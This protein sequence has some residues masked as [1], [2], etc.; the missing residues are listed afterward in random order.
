[1]GRAVRVLGV[2]LGLLGAGTHSA[3]AQAV[4]TGTVKD[5]TG[6]VLPVRPSEVASRR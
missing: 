2:V 4:V 1:M 5:T 6:A 3:F